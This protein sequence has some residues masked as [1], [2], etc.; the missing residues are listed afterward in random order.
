MRGILISTPVILV[1][2]L[3]VT[4][5]AAAQLGPPPSGLA[6]D[7]FPT[8]KPKLVVTTP[9]FKNLGDIPF[10]N[11]QYRGNAFPGLKWTHGPYGTRSFAVIMQDADVRLPGGTAL[12]HWSMYAVPAGVT[13][14]DPGVAAPPAG[15][16][17]G[18][19]FRGPNQS[20]LGPRTPPGPRHHYHFQVFALDREIAPDPALSRD[21]L[22][23]D[24][25]GHVL[26]TGEV[27]GLGRA[28][29]QPGPATK[30]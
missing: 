28:P 26:A 9:A 11:T 20:Y 15:A 23:A 7:A 16:S 13:H 2:L 30:P 27:V 8:A 4:S 12:T 19:N 10:E 17:F 24:M 29:D 3:V 18:P 14:L 21:A 22:A 6:I 1:A 25:T 5:I